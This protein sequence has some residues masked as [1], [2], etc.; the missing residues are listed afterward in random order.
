METI[1]KFDAALN[2]A[3]DKFIDA[4]NVAGSEWATEVDRLMQEANGLPGHLVAACLNS[5]VARIEEEVEG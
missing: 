5:A 2:V 3:A 1:E 4:C